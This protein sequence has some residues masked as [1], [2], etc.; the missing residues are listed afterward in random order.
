[1]HVNSL[2]RRRMHSHGSVVFKTAVLPYGR[3]RC[4][5]SMAFFLRPIVLPRVKRGNQTKERA[6]FLFGTHQAKIDPCYHT[7][8]EDRLL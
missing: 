6:E 3:A 2:C 1:M 4:T 7:V 8:I 5:Q